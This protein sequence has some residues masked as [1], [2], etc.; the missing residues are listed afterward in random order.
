MNG[1]SR[2]PLRRVGR[3]NVSS[4]DAGGPTEYI[5]EVDGWAEIKKYRHWYRDLLLYR[6]LS[7]MN[8]VQWI[9]VGRDACTHMTRMG[10][11]QLPERN[12]PDTRVGRMNWCPGQTGGPSPGTGEEWAGYTGWPD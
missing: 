3:E 5:L 1:E 7:I 9:R 6:T 12:G 4:R 8:G 11:G 2:L 10:R